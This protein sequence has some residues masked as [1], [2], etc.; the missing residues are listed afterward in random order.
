M[1]IAPTLQI[2]RTQIAPEN[3]HPDVRR[4]SQMAH[5]ITR[6]IPA[7]HAL[8]DAQ[9]PGGGWPTG[10][11]IDLLNQQEGGGSLRLVAPALRQAAHRKIIL[12]SPPHIPNAIAFVGLGIAPERLVWLRPSTTAEA[13]WAA[14][15]VL[16]A[17]GASGLLMWAPHARPESL[18]RLNLAAA[19]GDALF[20]LFRP[21]TNVQDHSPAPLRLALRPAP[22]GI[23]I[24]FVKRRGPLRAEPLFLPLPIEGLQSSVVHQRPNQPP[25][26]IPRTPRAPAQ[27]M[28]TQPRELIY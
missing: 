12:I 7:G 1:S 26:E 9:L 25:M 24:T 5:A 22:G 17:Q 2:D 21:L 4:A 18:R 15:T 27:T 11:Q 28:L 10:V 23:S 14:E 13:C 19:S 16:K 20:F 3:L 6:C 8:L